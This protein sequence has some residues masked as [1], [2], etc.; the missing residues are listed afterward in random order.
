[1]ATNL[2]DTT[3]GPPPPEQELLRTAIQH[4]DSGD[5]RQAEIACRQI[6]SLNPQHAWALFLLGVLSHKAGDRVRA[7]WLMKRAVMRD[8]FVAPFHTTLGRLLYRRGAFADATA[9]W[10]ES[11]SL[12]PADA[13]ARFS[14]GVVMLERGQVDA[15]I[16]SLKQSV[17]LCPEHAAAFEMLGRAQYLAGDYRAALESLTHAARLAPGDAQTVR[18]LNTIPVIPESRDG[19]LHARRRFEEQLAALL[20]QGLVLHDPVRDIQPQLFLTYQ[21]GDELPLQRD[22]ARLYLKSCPALRYTSPDLKERL[23]HPR[24]KIRVG[25]I[26]ATFDLPGNSDNT[27]TKDILRH[28]P[29]ERF[30]VYAFSAGW[31]FATEITEALHHPEDRAVGLS[32]T[33]AEA[34]AQ[35]EAAQ[36]DVLFY[37][38]P[39]QGPL[40]YALAFSRLAP[41]Q[42]TFWGWPATTGLATIDYFLTG[43]GD[44]VPHAQEHYCERLARLRHRP[45]YFHRPPPPARLEPR[46]H[47]ALEE[48]R[49]LYLCPMT[50]TKFHPDFDDIMAGILRADP[51]G[52]IVLVNNSMR[53]MF[54]LLLRRWREHMPDVADRICFV[55]RQPPHAFLNL[56]E[57]CDV[58]LDTPHFNGG[59]TSLVA[60]AVGAPVVTLPTEFLRGRFT[61][62]YYKQMG[63]TECV[64]ADAQDY[65]DIAVRLGTDGA[66]RARVK[67]EILARCHVLYENME[68]IKEVEQFLIHAVRHARDAL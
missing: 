50:P 12:D 3:P 10:R 22:L 56:L 35:L 11:L 44:E 49:H 25:F 33:L 67:A 5:L 24:D 2:T 19:L 31:G 52:E 8:P 9:H 16:E 63:L 30:S 20:E 36:L 59:T 42:C 43:D 58:I 65:V 48:D 13:E 4:Y 17:S 57:V 14:L 32:G 37:V 18:L 51:L 62:A 68:A 64:A 54:R 23:R 61:Y 26:S 47:F 28:L 55:P 6:L 53:D 1:M 29:R 7:E 40:T 60:F 45:V 39:N 46:S 34:R 15:A 27:V 21:G 66:H 38:R 41:V